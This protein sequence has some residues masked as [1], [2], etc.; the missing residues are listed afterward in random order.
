MGAALRCYIDLCLP[1][2]SFQNFNDVNTLM[3]SGLTSP[4]HRL[5]PNL[6]T[7]L[8][9]WVSRI[10]LG[11]ALLS[12]L[13]IATSVG[14]NHE[15][16]FRHALWHCMPVASE[17]PSGGVGLGIRLLWVVASAFVAIVCSSMLQSAVVVPEIQDGDMSFDEMVTNNC[18]FVSSQ[19]LG[20]QTGG[21]MAQRTLDA[22]VDEDKRRKMDFLR[23]EVK[24]GELVQ[25]AEFRIEKF[26]SF[27]L[28]ASLNNCKVIVASLKMQD[29]FAHILK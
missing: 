3:S 22:I 26:G 16:S 24:L 20:F 11:S 8:E 19:H 9:A 23:K 7:P 17:E 28:E 10:F 12:C 6:I 13:I 18:T 21:L 4:D 25:V 2:L 29:T 14:K 27:L 1:S 5:L 15:S